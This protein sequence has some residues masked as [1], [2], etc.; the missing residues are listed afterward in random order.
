MGFIKNLVAKLNPAQPNMAREEYSRRTSN[1]APGTTGAAY[2]SVEIVNRGVNLLIDS[3]ALVD[4]SVGE[5]ASFTTLAAVSSKGG[6]RKE[7]LKEI[8]NVRPNPHMDVSA[9]RRLLFMDFYMEGWAFIHWDGTSLYHIPAAHME[10][11]ADKKA[12]ISKYVYNGDVE[13]APH[14]IILIKDNAYSG[15]TVN[16]MGGQSRVASCLKS[17][18]R[19]EELVKF[20]QNFFKNG[21]VVS[22]I[23]ETEAVLSRKLRKRFE[24]EVSLDYNPNTGKSSVLVLDAGMKAKSLTPTSTKDLEIKSDVDDL[25]KKILQG[26]GVPP[27]L[28]DSGNN[29]N[30][31]PNI[32]L[33]Y[34][35][36]I[37]PTVK[38]FES[39]LALFFGYDIKVN[40]DNVSA[41]APDKEK[42]AKAVTAKVNNGVITGNEGRTEL[43]YE[44]ID[45]PAMDTI[46]IPA[47]IAGSATGVSGE[48]GGKPPAEED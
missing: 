43:R 47:N 6:V 1:T 30:I 48:E 9:F 3:S 22:L 4:F 25:E 42:E 7:K 19:R 34:H 13:Y 44:K 45:D 11:Y 40:I 33:F 28:L 29:A 2:K 39:A 38:K 24:N 26:L 15:N 46:R 20:K 21:A 37:I 23:V 14:E 8:L 17:V 18:V 31:R 5:K 32:D 12:Y 35:T 27:L 16:R 36:T 41:L 10:V